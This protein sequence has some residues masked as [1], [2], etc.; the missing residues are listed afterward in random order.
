M[1][2]SIASEG[3]LSAASED[4]GNKFY[5]VACCSGTS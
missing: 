3:C 1:Q 4:L 2:E 5:A